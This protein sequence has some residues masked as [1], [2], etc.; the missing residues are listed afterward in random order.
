VA[1]GSEGSETQ[2]RA[3]WLRLLVGAGLGLLLG[4]GGAAVTSGVFLALYH[5]HGGGDVGDWSFLAVIVV[6]A[7][8]GIPLGGIAGLVWS[9]LK[10][11]WWQ[12]AAGMGGVGLA[13]G[14]VSV[15]ALSR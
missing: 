15:F 8:A 13:S 2:R 11:P 5:P 14:L 10:R 4:L 12:L 6:S 1:M 7:L 9:W 3:L